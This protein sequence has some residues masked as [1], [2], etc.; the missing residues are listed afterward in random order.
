MERISQPEASQLVD[1]YRCAQ[2]CAA[3]PT[4]P[5]L[6]GPPHPTKSRTP[7]TPG[8]CR[9]FAGRRW[10]GGWLG[11]GLAG[12]CVE[13]LEEHAFQRYRRVYR[14]Q[15]AAALVELGDEGRQRGLGQFAFELAVAAIASR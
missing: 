13:D 15:V 7:Q 4:R 2:T 1:G 9:H 6:R 5:G 10:F 14:E 11:L 8:L 12:G 3:R